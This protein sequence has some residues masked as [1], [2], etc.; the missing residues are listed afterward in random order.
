MAEEKKKYLLIWVIEFAAVLAAD[1]S[2]YLAVPMKGLVWVV[3]Y[4]VQ[5]LT[6]YI[7]PYFLL[8]RKKLDSEQFRVSILRHCIVQLFLGLGYCLLGLFSHRVLGEKAGVLALIL[9]LFVTGAAHFLLAGNYV[10]NISLPLSGTGKKLLKVDLY[11]YA[12]LIPV[13][14]QVLM[15]AVYEV[16]PFGEQAYLR[17][18]CYHQY[19]PFL[20]E[21]Y[22]KVHEGSGLFFA[23][24]NGLGVNYWAHFSYYLSSPIN[25][26][27]L[28]LPQKY[29][30]EGIELGII[31]KSGLASAA[32]LY[33][34]NSKWK[35]R[36]V[37][38]LMFAVFYGLSAF[39]LAYSCNIMWTDSYVLFPLIML[40]VERISKGESARLYGIALCLSIYANFYISI[41]SG[42]AIVLYFI[43]C[44]IINS[45]E[46]KTVIKI[47]KFIL[48]TVV[49]LMIA[50]IILLPV[51]LCLSATPAGASE[52]PDAMKLYFDYHELFG[53][54]L[55]NVNSIQNDSDLP[56]IYASI[57][58]L[59]LFLLYMTN[60]GIQLKSK[61]TKGL[62]VLFMLFS[63]QVNYL[64]YIWHGFHFPNSFPAR[65]SF[66]YIFLIL[67][68]AS[69]CYE[70]RKSI[71]RLEI[72]VITV[73][74]AAGTGV[75]WY[76]LA[77]DDLVDGITTYLCSILFF[78]IYG[79]L[80]FLSKM[81]GGKAVRALF[82]TV[83]IIECLSNT[84][85]VGINSTINRAD[86][87][88]E[89]VILSD[90]LSYL[91]RQNADMNAG[92]YRV[93]KINDKY[94]NE[95][96]WHG[97]KGASYFSSTISGGVKEF[98]EAMGMRQSDVAYSFLKANPFMASFLGIKY[99]VSNKEYAPG[100]TY[101]GMEVSNGEDTL[102]VY[103]NLYP[104]SVG[105]A[106]PANA[107]DTLEWDKLR[108]PFKNEEKLYDFL[109]ENATEDDNLYRKMIPCKVIENETFSYGDQSD[110]EITGTATVFYVPAGEHPFFYVNQYI[111]EMRII[112][113][114]GEGEL[115]D[116]RKETELKFRRILDLGVYD[117]ER[118]LYFINIEDPKL[119][120]SFQAYSFR[121]DKYIS[122]ME[123]LRRE[124][125]ELTDYSAGKLEGN[126]TV[127]EDRTLMFSV[128]YDEGFTVLVDGKKVQTK[129]FAGAFLSVPLTAGT[130]SVKVSYTPPGFWAGVLLSA[131]GVLLS[132]LWLILSEKRKRKSLAK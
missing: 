75:L 2:L 13:I 131:G 112:S 113:R 30:I 114:D 84:L 110:N 91:D 81:V 108:E 41:I 97:Y 117:D 76:F 94:M 127:E 45:K 56:N 89:D 61:I 87:L 72:A 125:L 124:Q 128:P 88:K 83:A 12:F 10:F 16:Y 52:F 22:R 43:I 107:P 5:V 29:L 78:I 93:E 25:L 102:Y 36:D 65:E 34:I 68:M 96:A 14:I 74:L 6:S 104:L 58:A 59:M 11:L 44:C 21:Y 27:Y 26:F 132:A 47:L 32:F 66:F 49:V 19:A 7:T 55:V 8:Y 60:D 106:I 62:L 67:S 42:I 9:I 63:F 23:W 121:N 37:L 15:Y 24:E 3:I 18:D 122:L 54:M 111:D 95:A 20:K 123:K 28:I 101:S 116:T 99:L 73:F 103:E 33:Y 118:Y 98:F 50:A 46:G 64:D 31:L 85:A 86:Y 82:L 69:E 53:R 57:P 1:I 120:L 115:I 70:N 39:M 4:I 40:G 80:L 126:I 71:S 38:R 90:G 17:M 100:I 129:A 77:A 48:T 92:F 130:H 109:A 79:V 105:F 35:G 51:Y 119:E